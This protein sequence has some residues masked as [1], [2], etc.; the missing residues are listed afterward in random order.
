MSASG[1][2]V[3]ARFRSLGRVMLLAAV[4]ASPCAAAAQ[5]TATGGSAAA[6]K[7]AAPEDKR[8][9]DN[10]YVIGPSDVL[11]INVWKEADLTRTLP[12]RSDGK[13]SL[14]LV[15]EIQAADKTPMQ[16]ESELAKRLASF[17]TEPTVT[18]IVEQ[19]NSKKFNILG[20]VG[21]PG[22]YSLLL[23]SN[24][25]DAIAAAGGFKDFAKQTG[26]Y[27]LRQKADGTQARIPFNYKKF[28]RGKDGVQNLP[29]EAG[30]TIIVP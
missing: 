30:D 27:I 24:I 11:A 21:K 28:I 3:S 13:I 12:V 1:L 26:V 6:E 16:L 20:Q 9:H 25:V 2:F 7:Q 15:G 18:V 17:I 23:A 14:P 8:A 10:A 29:L 22:S 4:A 19:A 5:A